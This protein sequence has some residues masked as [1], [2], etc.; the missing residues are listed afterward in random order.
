VASLLTSILDSF[1]KNLPLR[2]FLDQMRRIEFPKIL[3]A[4]IKV[5]QSNYVALAADLNRQAAPVRKRT[6][7]EGDSTTFEVRKYS[8]CSRGGKSL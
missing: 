1:G 7:E 5:F 4:T 3:F 2:H 8:Q 6:R